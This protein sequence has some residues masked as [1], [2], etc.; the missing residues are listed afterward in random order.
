MNKLSLINISA[1]CVFLSV[2]CP[3]HAE[4]PSTAPN[5]QGKQE[6]AA[7]KK[8]F[9]AFTG[10]VT[11]NKVRLRIQPNLEGG[12]AR[13]L[14][15]GEMLIVVGEAD[16]FYTV[17]PPQDIK[18]YVFRTYVLDNKIEG[19]HVNV[20]IEPN[21]EAQVIAQM[22]TGDVVHG[23][24]SASNN[25]WLEIAPPAATRLF[26]SKEFIEKAGDATY[27]ARMA[28]RDEESKD[29]LGAAL[30]FSQKQ[31]ELPFSQIRLKEVLRNYQKV[32]RNY[33]YFP[34]QVQ[35]A[36]EQMSRFQGCLFTEK[37][38]LLGSK[39]ATRQPTAGESAGEPACGSTACRTAQSSHCSG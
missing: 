16:D 1:T 19:S 30:L 31:L 9:E 29:L 10:K 34:A 8:V 4:T 22:N 12:I 25:K 2:F 36:K 20:R 28:K 32:V 6:I 37:N 13:E 18:G 24:I 17:M 23:S 38:S 3:S 39:S 35:L 27:L 21:T 15:A 11:K 26:V 7:P 14:T 33:P 5:P